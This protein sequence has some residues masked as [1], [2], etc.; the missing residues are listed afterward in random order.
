MKI[1]QFFI[2][3]ILFT[4]T[5]LAG[6]HFQSTPVASI[7]S[8]GAL[9]V[10]FDEAGLGK[11]NVDYELDATGSADFACFNKAGKQP[12]AANKE[13][14]AVTVVAQGSFQ[15][16]N[17]RVRAT[18]TG[19]VPTAGSF[20]CPPGF[21]ILRLVEVTYSGILLCDTTN[22]VCASPTPD[23]IHTTF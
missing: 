12:P 2:H 16:K 14:V 15:P 1:Y 8:S 11:T 7:T 4:A 3:L 17:G 18:I 21:Q 5:A 20:S 9:S 19:P 6:P 13:T 22:D 10:S 23:P